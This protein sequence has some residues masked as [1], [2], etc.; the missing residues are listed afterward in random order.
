MYFILQDMRKV[1]VHVEKM[2]RGKSELLTIES[3]SYKWDYRLIPKD[4]EEK[5]LS[6]KVEQS[7]TVLPKTMDFPPVL[8]EL[9]IR[10]A[11]ARG[12][13]DIKEPRLDIVYNKMS[14]KKKYRIAQDGEKPDV[15]F[16]MGL[17]IPASP[18]LYENAKLNQ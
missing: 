6:S 11:K 1:R 10:E 15:T 12:E 17:G 3:A 2:F 7:I 8:R 5:Y 16:D 14:T 13:T 9:L 18:H 4:E